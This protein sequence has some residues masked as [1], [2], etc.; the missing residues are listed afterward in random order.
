M[1]LSYFT[2]KPKSNTQKYVT[3]LDLK[4]EMLIFKSILI[5]LNRASFFEAAGVVDSRLK[6]NHN[7][8][9]TID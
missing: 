5:P 4:S 3:D 7:E 2:V 6:S 1:D 9:I 8:Q